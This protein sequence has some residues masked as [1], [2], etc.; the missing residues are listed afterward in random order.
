MRSCYARPEAESF[1]QTCCKRARRRMSNPIP[2]E[3]SFTMPDPS[4]TADEYLTIK[5]LSALLK[6][7]EPTLRYWRHCGKAPRAIK[8]NG[9]L[10]FPRSGVLAWLEKHA[11]TDPAA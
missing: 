7:P 10:R 5:E 4:P 11:E 1:R 2:E 9:T 3:V 8:I 6:V